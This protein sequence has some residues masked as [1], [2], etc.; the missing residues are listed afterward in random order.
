MRDTRSGP[1]PLSL[2]P[3]DQRLGMGGEGWGKE[4]GVDRGGVPVIVLI[5]YNLRISICFI[6]RQIASLKKLAIMSLQ[7]SFPQILLINFLDRVCTSPEI[8]IT[9]STDISHQKSSKQKS[10]KF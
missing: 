10:Y 3:F 9:Y 8:A 4:K 2:L 6:T 5:G 1:F 7:S